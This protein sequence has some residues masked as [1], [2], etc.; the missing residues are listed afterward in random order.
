MFLACLNALVYFVT[1]PRHLTIP[2]THFFQVNLKCQLTHPLPWAEIILYIYWLCRWTV[3]PF[4]KK[5][6]QRRLDHSRL[7]LTIFVFLRGEAWQKIWPI[8]AG[9]LQKCDFK[10]KG[11]CCI[12]VGNGPLTKSLL[13][14]QSGSKWKRTVFLHRESE[15]VH[16]KPI[17]WPWLAQELHRKEETQLKFFTLL[18]LQKQSFFFLLRYTNGR[19]QVLK[20]KPWGR[21][22]VS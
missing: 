8:R 14:P 6:T 16:K 21:G 12:K 13:K 11:P 1:L 2:L 10:N 4:D 3:Q 17:Q 15:Q 7:A 20:D 22:W 9:H 18:G 5:K 19:G